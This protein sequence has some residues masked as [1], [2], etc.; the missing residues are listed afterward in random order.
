MWAPSTSG[1]DVEDLAAQR[2]HGLGLAIACLFGA[3]AGRIALDD[4]QLA[5]FAGR[6]GTIGE[7]AGQAQFLHRG[8]AGNFLFGA[9]A[10]PFVGALDDEIQQLVGLQRIARQPMV[11]RVLDRVL[12]DLLRRRGGQPILGLALEFR[13]ADEDR[14]HAAGTDHHVFAGHGRGALVQAAT[15]GVIL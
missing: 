3:A 2:H 9:P 8:L 15:L 10:Q 5:S 6:I 13:L 11:E 4:E 12:D 7:L 14:E 1:G